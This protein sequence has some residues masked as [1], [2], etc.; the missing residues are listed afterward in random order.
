MATILVDTWTL[1]WVLDTPEKL[2]EAA[3]EAIG[4]EGNRVLG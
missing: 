2:G 4:S 1:L 3:R